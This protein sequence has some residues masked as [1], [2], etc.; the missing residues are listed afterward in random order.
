MGYTTY[1]N[2]SLEFNKPVTEELKNF[3]LIGK[4]NVIME[5]LVQMEN[6]SLVVKDL[7][8]RKEMIVL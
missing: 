2:G 3:I 8:G 4:R 6:T 7:W 1:F 5:T